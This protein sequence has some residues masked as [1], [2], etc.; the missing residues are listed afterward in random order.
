MLVLIN[1]PSESKQQ[2]IKLYRVIIGSGRSEA[3]QDKPNLGARTETKADRT[4]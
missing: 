2:E 3:E 4:D 1:A